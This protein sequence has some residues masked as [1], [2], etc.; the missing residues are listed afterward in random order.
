MRPIRPGRPAVAATLVVVACLTG[1]VANPAAAEPAGAYRPP[2]DRPVVDPWRPP[3]RPYGPGNRGIDYATVPQEE[4]RAA[5]DGEVTF[6]GPVGGSL[7]VTVLHPDGL[8]TSYSFLHAVTVRRG[9]RVGRGQPVGTAGS[10]LHFGVRAGDRYLDPNLLFGGGPADV[11]LVPDSWRSPRPEAEE[12]WWLAAVA[13]RGLAAT[14]SALAWAAEGTEVLDH[15]LAQ[16]VGFGAHVAHLRRQGG[17]FGDAQRGCSPAA[18]P[19]GPPPPG[20][21]IAVLVAGFGSTGGDAGILALDTAAL[22]YDDADVVQLSY[23]GG[24]VPGVGGLPGVAATGYGPA[25]TMVDIR[26]PAQH[27]RD[28]LGAIREAHPG[29]PVDVIAHS[30]GGLV[31]RAALGRGGDAVDPRLPPIGHLITLGTPHDGTDLATAGA[32]LGSTWVGEV[33]GRVARSVTGGAVDP[34]SEAAAQLA[35]TSSFVAA[36]RDRPLPAGTRVT[37]IAARGD[38]VVP[39]LHSALPGATNV[40]VPLDG[41]GAHHALPGSAEVQREVA[42][43]LA[44]RGPTCRDLTVDVGLAAGIGLATDAAGTVVGVTA[45]ALDGGADLLP[46]GLPGGPRLGPSRPEPLCL[47]PVCEG[48]EGG[49]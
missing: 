38:V 32:L 49:R 44:G 45:T 24:R 16:W 42:L 23:R 25:D 12:R 5:G 33:A 14:A 37:S 27:L 46:G 4:V 39:A 41:L 26:V 10:R 43:A 40:M 8:R 7:H 17:L 19:A 6:A 34:A 9:D 29:V 31:A 3:D 15:Y 1:A 2:V 30:Q 47:D 11:H 28:L 22:G 48:G 36:V 13:A 21:R 18:V 35:E 20:R